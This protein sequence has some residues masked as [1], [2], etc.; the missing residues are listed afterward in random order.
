MTPDYYAAQ[1]ALHDAINEA[2]RDAGIDLDKDPG[3]YDRTYRRLEAERHPAYVALEDAHPSDAARKWAF[4]ARMRREG[5]DQAEAADRW[6]REQRRL[7][8][9]EAGG[10][11][12]MRLSARHAG[13]DVAYPVD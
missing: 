7:S 6:D 3:A 2:L 5:L 12:T 9:A 10:G 11:R 4:I 13:H 8:A 1:D